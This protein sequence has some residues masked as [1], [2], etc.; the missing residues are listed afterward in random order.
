MATLRS[1]S[2]AN[3]EGGFIRERDLEFLLHTLNAK[4]T[5]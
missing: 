2:P 3:Y 5:R 1:D 4:A